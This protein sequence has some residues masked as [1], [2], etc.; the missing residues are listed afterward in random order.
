MTQFPI[1]VLSKSSLLYYGRT[2]TLLKLTIDPYC[3]HKNGIQVATK[4]QGDLYYF[5]IVEPLRVDNMDCGYCGSS[6]MKIPITA[7]FLETNKG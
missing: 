7:I 3:V 5:K 1:V 6:L 4:L 2:L